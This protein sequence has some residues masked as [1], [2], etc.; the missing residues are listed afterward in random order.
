MTNICR[1]WICS[2]NF[3]TMIAGTKRITLSPPTDFHLLKPRCVGRNKGLCYANIPEPNRPEVDTSYFNKLIVDVKPGEILYVPA[4]WF[5]HIENL[6]PTVMANM[7]SFGQ[8]TCAVI[9]AN[10]RW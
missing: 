9:N 2:D 5:H 8:E 6:G 3:I 7:W 1:H 10:K 4:G